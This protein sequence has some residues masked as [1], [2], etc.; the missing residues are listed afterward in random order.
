MPVA[1]LPE[2]TTDDA[3]QAQCKG[4]CRRSLIDF[5]PESLEEVGQSISEFLSPVA[6]TIVNGKQFDQFWKAPGPWKNR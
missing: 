6:E 2:F 3:K 4:F 1:F 5:A